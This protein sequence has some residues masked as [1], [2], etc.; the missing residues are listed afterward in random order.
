MDKVF[1]FYPIVTNYLTEIEQMQTVKELYFNLVFIP[2]YMMQ[3]I[4]ETFLNDCDNHKV[5]NILLKHN[6]VN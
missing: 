1:S 2:F 6:Y 4:S 5:P 3:E